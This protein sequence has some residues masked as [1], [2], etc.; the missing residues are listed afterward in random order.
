MP[1][2]AHE[3]YGLSLLTDGN[4]MEN[5]REITNLLTNITIGGRYDGRFY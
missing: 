2:F 4:E 5:P 1:N 3:V